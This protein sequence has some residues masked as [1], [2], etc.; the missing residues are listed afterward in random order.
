MLRGIWPGFFSANAFGNLYF[1]NATLYNRDRPV[2]RKYVPILQSI[3]KAGWQ[4]VTHARIAKAPA[5]GSGSGVF[6]ER[7]G[8][9]VS[10]QWKNPDFLS[11][12]LISYQESC[13]FYW[14]L[15]IL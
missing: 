11:R 3:N 6:L 10:F 15:L 14:K 5:V 1:S 9:E 13:F 2:F 7:W 8:G 12:I 4:P